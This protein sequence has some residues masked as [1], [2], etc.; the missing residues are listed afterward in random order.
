EEYGEEAL[1]LFRDRARHETGFVARLRLWLD[2]I[3]D[4]TISLPREYF[5]IPSPSAVPSGSP[6]LRGVP[7]FHVLST[8]PIRAS[9]L[10]SGGV[11]SFVILTSCWI[12]LNGAI[13]PH[14]YLAKPVPNS[15]NDSGSAQSAESSAYDSSAAASGR[16]VSK[17]GQLSAADR[18]RL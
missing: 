2:L 6:P 15:R 13:S 9:A 17:N 8:E 12:S 4:A 14:N 16:S 7:S 10:L 5:H 1:R 3:F 11:L 18:K